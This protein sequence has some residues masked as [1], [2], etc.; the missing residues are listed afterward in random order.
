MSNKAVLFHSHLIHSISLQFLIF[1]ESFLKQ[2]ENFLIR[3][4][5]CLNVHGQYIENRV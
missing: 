1:Y 3:V 5:N 2:E 4:A